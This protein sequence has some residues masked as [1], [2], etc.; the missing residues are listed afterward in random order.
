MPERPGDFLDGSLFDPLRQLRVP[1]LRDGW[2]IRFPHVG[3]KSINCATK[4]V[5]VYVQF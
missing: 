3:V 5:Y 1:D 2:L 4:L